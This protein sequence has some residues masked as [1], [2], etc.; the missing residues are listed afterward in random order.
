[1]IFYFASGL[2]RK[3]FSI[4]HYLMII[5]HVLLLLIFILSKQASGESNVA[6]KKDMCL[7]YSVKALHIWNNL[8]YKP[9]VGIF[10]SKYEGMCVLTRYRGNPLL[11][12]FTRGFYLLVYVLYIFQYIH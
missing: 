2:Q 7:W 10:S 5:T 9:L 8:I 12:P 3:A 4:K 1:M 6:K 11:L